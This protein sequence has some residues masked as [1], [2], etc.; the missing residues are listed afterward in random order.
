[1]SK[2]ITTSAHTTATVIDLTPTTGPAL[3]ARKCTCGEFT[4]Y[5]LSKPEARHA[6]FTHEVAK[7]HEAAKRVAGM[8]YGGE[9]YGTQRALVIAA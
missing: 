8:R 4:G 7:R 5:Y 2:I 3:F 6:Q 9:P 1:M